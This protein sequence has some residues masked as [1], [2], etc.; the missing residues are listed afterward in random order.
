MERPTD[1]KVSVRFPSRGLMTRVPPV[2]TPEAHLEMMRSVTAAKN[3]RFE[4]GVMTNGPG[5]TNVPVTGGTALDS[6]PYFIW[7]SNLDTSIPAQN[8]TLFIGSATK[9]FQATQAY[10]SGTGVYS[11]SLSD[12][13][14]SSLTVNYADRWSAVNFLDKALLNHKTQKAKYWTPSQSLKDLPG[15]SPSARFDGLT[16]FANH[17]L[18][19][20]SNTLKW[21]TLNDF[22]NYIPIGLTIS[23]FIL[24]TTA[25]FTQPAP[26]ASV[27]VNLSADPLLKNVTVGQFVRIDYN[28]GGTDFFNFYS[29]SAVSAS[30]AQVTLVRLDLTGCTATSGTVPSGVSIVSLDA[31][32]AG[33]VKNIEPGGVIYQVALLGDNAY[34]FKHRSIQSIQYVG[35]NAGTFFIRPEIL[36]EGLISRHALVSIGQGRIIFLGNYELYDYRGGPALS[37]ICQHH[38]RQLFNELDRTKLERI[39]MFHKEDRN[40][41]WV[42]Y[43]AKGAAGPRVMIWNY[44]ENTASIDDYDGVLGFTSIATVN[45]NTDLTWGELSGSW[46]SLPGTWGDLGAGGRR[47]LTIIG[48]KEATPKL[49]VHGL[50]YNID[51]VAYTSE[52]E[53][54][55]FDF[56]NDMRWKYIHTVE[57]NLHI[58]SSLTGP[59][60]LNVY[61]GARDNLDSPIRWS[62]AQTIGVK[63][64]DQRTAKVNFNV[65]GRFARLKFSSNTAGIQFRIAGFRIFARPGGVY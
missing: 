50:T 2:L 6:E 32:E 18:L 3:M 40:E 12:F 49:Y 48:L 55:D 8:E 10:N 9:L 31:N 24:T 17:V 46:S 37:P 36:D 25:A 35:I 34:I 51:G 30:P 7:Q 42:I 26:G 63:G 65:G 56:G 43:P 15:L 41:V 23:S 1:L 38:T 54:F 62:A 45:W 60:N 33:E 57:L 19:W 58:T 13:G 28:S 64:G 22:S 5:R 39:S 4:D 59:H 20:S 14:L 16:T 29:V 61:V 53:T 47:R 11:V 44:V 21:S 52:C 27:V